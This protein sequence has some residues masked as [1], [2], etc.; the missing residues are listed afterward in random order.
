MNTVS[1]RALRCFDAPRAADRSLQ[2]VAL[3]SCVGLVVSLGLM[4]FGFDLGIGWV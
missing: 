4:S 2:A 3:L 1:S